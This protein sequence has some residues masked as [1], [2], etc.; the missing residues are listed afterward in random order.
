MGLSAKSR[1]KAD[2]VAELSAQV[3]A[4][5]ARLERL[6]RPSPNGHSNST[7][8]GGGQGGGS[9]SRRDLL[10]LAGA[11][12]A[13][14]AGS[15]VLGAVPAAATNGQPILLGNSTTNDT[16]TTTTIFPT[17]ATTP[18]PLFEGIGQSVTGPTTVPPTVSTTGPAAQSIPVIGAIGPGGS[19]PAI[20]S[21]AVNDYPG[22]APIQ[23]VGGDTTVGG[24]HYSEGVNGWGISATG[25]G[26]SGESDVGYGVVGGSGGI[27]LAAFKNG[28]IMQEGPQPSMLAS[29]PA[30]PPIYQPND[31]EQV[32]DLNGLMYLSLTGQQWVPVQFGG[33]GVSL[34]SAVSNQQY[35]LAGSDGSTW[36]DMDATV[37]KLTITP[38]FNCV[39]ILTANSDLW[40]AVAGW[41]QDLG[42]LVNGGSYSNVIVG[43]KESG[44]YAGT[45]SPNAA[46]LES[47]AQFT[48][49][50]TYTIKI[51]WKTNRP[52]AATTSIFAGAGQAPYSPTRLTALLIVNPT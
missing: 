39:A 38:K 3:E 31:F 43:W 26:V 6:E 9:Q 24:V 32:R 12:A 37:L 13:G 29:A 40:T 50:T 52:A 14:A 11:A 19:L 1:R 45:F 27:S 15:I 47:L 48:A 16:A 10:K 25:I 23:G 36:M 51:Q 33:L 42:I 7:P 21:P 49:G 41:N 2:K 8:P 28:R 35:R 18:A 44:G 17:T 30:G 46:F 5:Q 22:F 4:L 20:G 34:F